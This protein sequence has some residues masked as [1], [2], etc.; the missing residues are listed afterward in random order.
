MH[1][2]LSEMRKDLEN[3]KTL[4]F[5]RAPFLGILLH[6]MRIVLNGEVPT[7][8]ATT[9][10]EVLV[11]PFYWSRI[12][13][14]EAKTFLLLHEA[15]HLGFRH[16]WQLDGKD[17]DAW[18]LAVDAVVNEMLFHHGYAKAPRKPITAHTIHGMLK[19]RGVEVSIEELRKS[20]AE[21]IY[22]LLVDAQDDPG[23]CRNVLQEQKDLLVR[24]PDTGGDVVQDGAMSNQ[25]PGEYWRTALAEALVTARQAG[26]L[27]A[28]IE[29]H[30]DASLTTVV[31]WQRQLRGSLQEGTGRTVVTTWH[32]S[33]RRYASL[34]GIKRLGVQT[35]WVLL[36]CSG[37]ITDEVLSRF[38][39]EVYSLARAFNCNLKVIPWDAR[40]Y[41]VVEV[42]TPSQARLKIPKGLRGGGGTVLK[43]ALLEASRMVRLQDI[44]VVFS[45]GHIWDDRDAATLDIYRRL[46]RRAARMVFVTTDKLPDL[47]RTRVIEMH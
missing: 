45:D 29:R 21:Q 17:V 19:E 18:N 36:D 6:K 30:V 22:K 44:V 4:L 11:N 10:G 13:E 34:P 25:D 26:L 46:A 23:A 40:V 15:L 47:P 33:S 9:S 16:P 32:R 31:N 3:I 7:I 37:S 38:V 43:P 20:S 8:G 42:R 1:K 2:V 39:G 27:P 14:T 28:D 24:R 12:D 41:P 35:I 5:L